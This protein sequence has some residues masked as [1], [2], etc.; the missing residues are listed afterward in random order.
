LS[1]NFAV[2]KRH[3]RVVLFFHHPIPIK[4]NRP[5]FTPTIVDGDILSL[6]AADHNIHLPPFGSFCGTLGSYPGN[7]D[8][9]AGCPMRGLKAND[10]P[11]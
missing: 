5:G 3:F 4:A 8:I 10:P 9:V 6:P 7:G 2:F 1:N 11:L